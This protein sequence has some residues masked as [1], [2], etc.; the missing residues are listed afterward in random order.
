MSTERARTDADGT[1]GRAWA[2]GLGP[3]GLLTVTLLTACA[4]GLPQ[5][6]AL[7]T[8]NTECAHCR[9]IASDVH[10]AAQIVAP[11]EEARFFDDIG[12]LRDYLKASPAL[13][14]ESVAYVADHRTA[15]WVAAADAVYTRVTGLNTPMDSGVVAHADSASRDADAAARGGASVSVSELFGPSGP[16]RR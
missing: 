3:W 8:R 15:E 14:S 1:R 5:P 4:G 10:F 9:M 7:D 11:G 2:L 6:A 13:A 12:C 16:P